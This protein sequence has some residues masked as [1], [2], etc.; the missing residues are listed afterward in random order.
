MKEV[1]FLVG[2]RIRSILI[3]FHDFE[4]SRWLSGRSDSTL[5]YWAVGRRNSNEKWIDP[6]T[7]VGSCWPCCLASFDILDVSTPDRRAMVQ[8][9]S[10]NRA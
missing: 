7:I 1:V 8:A 5:A 6:Q 9:P 2:N 4:A 10:P 3:H